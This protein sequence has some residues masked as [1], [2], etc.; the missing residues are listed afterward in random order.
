MAS[1]DSVPFDAIALL[2]ALNGVDFIVVGGAAAALH[3][4]PRVTFDLDV[5]PA[6]SESN[7][8]ALASALCVL[9]AVVREPGDRVIPV[10]LDLLDASRVAPSGGQIRLRTSHG[11]LDVLWRLHDGRGYRELLAG[12]VTLS[13]DEREIRVIGLDDLIDVK[14]HAGRPQDLADVRYLEQVR[15]RRGPQ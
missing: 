4:G 8:R 5:V 13:D 12:A 9:N 14:S 1:G 10:T 6:T 15:S 2:D 3:G 7:V 11:P